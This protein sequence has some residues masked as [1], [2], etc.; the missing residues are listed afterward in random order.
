MSDGS[1]P[2]P[3]ELAYPKELDGWEEMYPPYYIFSKDRTDW[4]DRQ[5]WYHDKIHAP[6]PMY[7]WDLIFHEAWQ[8]SLSQYNTR[9]FCI[10]PAQG[11]AQRMVGCYMYICAVEPPPPE[12]IQQKAEL[13]QKRVFYVFEHY[14]ELYEKWLKK[15]RAL[16]EE[17]ERL[18]IPE[19][20]PRFEGED[21][22]FPAPRGY[23]SSF[24]VMDAYDKLV[25]GI[26]KGWQ[27]HFEY[28]NLSYLGYLMFAD[29]CRKLFPG[30]SESTIGK[31]VAGAVVT[32]YRPEEELCKLA[33]MAS[34]MPSVK[35]V[36]KTDLAPQ[37][38]VERLSKDLDG[39]EW[40]RAL[41][42]VKNPWFYASCG[43]GWFH[44]EGSWINRP[45]VPFGYLRSYMERL[46]RGER[47]ER[48]LEEIEQER[49]KLAEDYRNLIANEDD[50]KAFEDAY[51][52]CRTIYKYAEDHL[53]WVEHWFH[54]I[55]FDKMWRLGA[56]LAKYGLL[57]EAEDVYLF[58]RFEVPMIIE[59]MV[60]AYAL[61]EGVPA[62][63]AHW[64]EKASRRRK[65]LDAARHWTP[66]PALGTV[67]EEIAE[68]F[69]VML[70]GV[71]SD[72][73]A[74]W[75][76]GA[77]VK[78]GEVTEVKGFASSA[79]VAEGKARVIKL[80]E[81]INTLEPGEILVCPTT[82]P[83]WAP[84]FTKIK[85][86]VTDIGGLTSHAAIVCREYGVPSVTGAGIATSVI[87]TGDIIR[88][89]G[90]KGVVHLV[91]RA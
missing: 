46:E 62:R 20:L 61:G 76:K 21:V 9:V 16:G 55:V 38:K 66:P 19:E 75:L 36:L 82:N 28:L 1:F 81:E 45:E 88:V 60:T 86:A 13:F 52:T 78:P 2:K 89:D 57:G 64:K 18:V 70:W 51:K 24:E 31:L 35:E 42:S 58:N 49:E 3:S 10:P 6:E 27:Y 54:T 43:S 12:V 37:E 59:D 47:I 63:A 77:A 26:I 4:E 83:S 17:I 48:Y 80:L 8:I 65:I 39:K 15:F 30:I 33:R 84:V 74:E 11:V 53:F 29:T 71:T 25:N 67:P 32:M 41:E 23:F 44:Y 72:K 5:F 50:K 79:G 56:L 90:N 22:V 91:Q 87:K 7:P 14:D 34:T 73:V 85:A 68:P 40:L 69:T